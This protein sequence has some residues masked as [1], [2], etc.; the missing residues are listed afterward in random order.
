MKQDILKQYVTLRTNLEKERAQLQARLGEI[1]QALGITVAPAAI[2]LQPSV[3]PAAEPEARQGKGAMSPEGRARLVAAQKARWAKVR[4]A[5]GATA[6]SAPKRQYSAAGRARLAEIA[7]A[8]W[9]KVHASG[10]TTL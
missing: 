9:A 2:A 7:K 5:K 8:R 3:A 1:E 4:A 10:K 6:P